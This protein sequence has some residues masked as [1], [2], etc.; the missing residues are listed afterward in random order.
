MKASTVNWKRYAIAAACAV[1]LAGLCTAAETK[2]DM[3]AAMMEGQ[4]ANDHDKAGGMDWIKHTRDTLGELKRKLN[5]TPAQAPAWDAWSAGI[6]GDAGH[7]LSSES[8][9]CEHMHGMGGEDLTTPEQMQHGIACL[10]A[11]TAEMEAHLSQLEAAQA[12]TKTFYEAL[13]TNQRTI[14]DMF[15]R[16][17]HHRFGAGEKHE[18]MGGM[19]DKSE[20]E[21]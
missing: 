7:Q 4:H 14:F 13:D 6:M 8:A 20:H 18:G 9:A 12:R 1:S 21:K 5:L 2:D 17:M 10:R 16:E 3:H 19:C 11:R 15:W